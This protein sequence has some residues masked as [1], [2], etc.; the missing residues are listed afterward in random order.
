MKIVHRTKLKTVRSGDRLELYRY[1]EPIKY[2]EPPQH[3]DSNLKPAEKSQSEKIKNRWLSSRRSKKTFTRLVYANIN[4]WEDLK[5]KIARP[6][7]LTLTFAEN[8]T[9]KKQANFEFTKFIKRLT[10]ETTRKKTSY[11]KYIVTVEFQGRGAI[12]Y[13]VLFFNLP[14]IPKKKIAQIWKQGFI[15]IKQAEDVKKTIDYLSK[16]MAKELSDDRLC[17]EKS[18]FCSRG[19]KKPVVTR[20]E[21]KIEF[22]TSLYEK[23]FEKAEEFRKSY[24]SDYCGEFEFF[25]YDL[26][27]SKKLKTEL[28]AFE[29][30]FGLQYETT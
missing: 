7:F 22:I 9:N 18:Y 28:L 13:H 29:K 6:T 12:H 19:L 10:Y 8:I 5:G 2:G 21:E 15:K 20:N 17:G 1:K 23:D 16:Y 3:I 4:Q 14:Y 24:K 26:K 27:K 30:L 11:L 25:I